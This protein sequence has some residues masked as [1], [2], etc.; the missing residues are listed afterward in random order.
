MS[1][2]YLVGLKDL[3]LNDVDR[4][5]FAWNPY[6]S[7]FHHGLNF[8]KSPVD[9]TSY[10]FEKSSHNG[11]VSRLSKFKK[12]L[13]AEKNLN[14]HFNSNINLK[15]LDHHL[16]HAASSFYCSGFEDSFV[17]VSDGAGEIAS[18][19]IFYFSRD[20][21]RLLY[22]NNFPDS[23]GLLYATVTQLLGFIPLIDEYKVMG[24]TPYG[25]P[26]YADKILDHIMD[27][28]DDGSFRLD[29]DYFDYC[30]GLRM[31][32]DRF[33]ELTFADVNKDS[34]LDIFGYAQREGRGVLWINTFE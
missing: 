8:L 17:F 25:Q 3:K 24:L 12:M 27:L 22:R 16:C 13:S 20:S 11:G 33:H 14:K 30:T 31:T 32:N 15:F 4:V 26:K 19:S 18:I 21:F 34:F 28:K 23:I 1:I 29:L 10:V 5:G 9:F 7:V 2:E 6:K